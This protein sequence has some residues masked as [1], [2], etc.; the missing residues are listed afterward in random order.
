MPLEEPL[1]MRPRAAI[2]MATSWS[3]E[4]SVLKG[5]GEWTRAGEGASAYEWLLDVLET[6]DDDDWLRLERVERSVVRS[7]SAVLQSSRGQSL[8]GR[9]GRRTDC[10]KHEHM[11]TLPQRSRPSDFLFL[12]IRTDLEMTPC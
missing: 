6:W 4:E 2:A 8:R 5:W 1:R 3:W 9:R 7:I 11:S 12:S 10:L